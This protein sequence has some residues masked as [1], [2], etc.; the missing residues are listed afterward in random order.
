MSKTFLTKVKMK[1]C[2]EMDSILIGA[3][4]IDRIYVGTGYKLRVFFLTSSEL[5]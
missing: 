4:D 3:V 5:I 2:F 1:W